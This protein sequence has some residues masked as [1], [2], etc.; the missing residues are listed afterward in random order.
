MEGKIIGN[1]SLIDSKIDFPKDG[2]NNYVICDNTYG[3]V[4]LE[5]STLTFKG[6]NSVIYLVG[7]SKKSF[8]FKLFV[9][10]GS[11]IYIGRDALFHKN[12]SVHITASEKCHVIVGSGTMVGNGVW[13]RTG[14]AHPVYST[15]TFERVNHGKNVI[16][17]DHVW[18][19]QDCIVLKGTTIG[20]GAIIGARSLA[21]KIYYSNTSYAGTP[22]RMIS[23]E[24][25]VFFDKFEANLCSEEKLKAAE[26]FE[27]DKFIFKYDKNENIIKSFNKFFIENED[28]EKRIEYYKNMSKNKSRFAIS[29][30]TLPEDL[31]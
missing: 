18:L 15:K 16:I 4:V 11:S 8:K 23:E 29:S 30:E 21:S 9:G 19:A 7:G 2:E 26:K 28:V 17:G 20:S 5:K 24:G 14:D 27:T 31:I 10:T 25:A 22:A 12:G 6:S 3:D 13:I 1:I